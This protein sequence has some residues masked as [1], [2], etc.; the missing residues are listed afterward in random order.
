[1]LPQREG[2]ALLPSCFLFPLCL[3]GLSCPTQ[4]YLSGSHSDVPAATLPAPNRMN[5]SLPLLQE[6][7]TFLRCHACP[8]ASQRSLPP[9]CEFS[10]GQAGTQSRT[11][12]VLLEITRMSSR[13]R[14]GAAIRCWS[15]R[16]LPVTLRIV[17]Y[18]KP[19]QGD[20]L[21]TSKSPAGLLAPQARWLSQ[22]PEQTMTP[23]N[24]SMVPL[25]W[26]QV[27]AVSSG[28]SPSLTLGDQGHQAGWSSPQLLHR[29]WLQPVF[30][31]SRSG[32]SG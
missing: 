16:S 31:W 6:H 18:A 4:T 5:R 20:S 27:W 21:S 28:D 32:Q 29:F 14:A 2:H 13:L 26:P 11:Q 25:S 30:V 22:D 23:D 8:L 12:Q 24:L 15:P 3:N 10:Q 7:G 9:S 19:C 1:M 17:F